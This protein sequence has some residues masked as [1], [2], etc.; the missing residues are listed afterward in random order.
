MVAR[1]HIHVID[2]NPARRAKI[3][4]ELY[5]PSIHAEIYESVEE[6][7]IRAPSHGSL[8]IADDDPAAAEE[9]LEELWSQSN[10][11]PA[12]FYS[13][14]PSPQRIVEAMLSGALDYLE[15]PFSSEMLD[16]SVRRLRRQSDQAA[17]VMRRK[18][19]ARQLVAM[20]TPRERD[21]LVVLLEGE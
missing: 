12:A 17:R 20:L 4:R 11:L 7:L 16:R 15:W 3:A 19:E 6:L 14:D 8:L 5:S 18:A 13:E 1:H 2:P 21:V 9:S 10:Y